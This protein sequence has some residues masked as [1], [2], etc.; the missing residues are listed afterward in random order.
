MIS[1]TLKNQNFFPQN[2]IGKNKIK[3]KVFEKCNSWK[4]NMKQWAKGLKRELYALYLCFKHEKTPLL[5]KIIIII[6]ISYAVNPI[7]H[8]F[9]T[10]LTQLCLHIKQIKSLLKY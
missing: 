2:L 9:L 8:S 10:S 1:V 4:N 7:F 5:A 3:M 6:T